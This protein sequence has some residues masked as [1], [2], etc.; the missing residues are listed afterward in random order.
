MSRREAA[1]EAPCAS[2]CSTRCIVFGW[3]VNAL[4]MLGERPVTRVPSAPMLQAADTAAGVTAA[5]AGAVPARRR[6]KKS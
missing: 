4:A 3:T 1:W 2:R 5:G 6:G